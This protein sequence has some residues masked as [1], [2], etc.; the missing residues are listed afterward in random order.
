MREQSADGDFLRGIKDLIP[1]I[2]KEEKWLFFPL[3]G[4]FL[5]FNFYQ[6]SHFSIS[7]DDE[8]AIMSPFPEVWI[9]QGRFIN[10]LF[11]KYLIQRPVMPFVPLAVFGVLVVGGYIFLLKSLRVPTAGSAFLF[12]PI[13]CAFPTW[14]LLTAFQANTPPAGLAVLACGYASWLFRQRCEQDDL[15]LSR[16]APSALI[17]MIAGAVATGCYQSF[18]LFFAITLLLPLL[19]LAREGRSVVRLGQDLRRA[20]LLLI[21]AGAVY[22]GVQRLFFS[23][24]M[25]SEAGAKLNADY[26]LGYVRFEAL[27]T[28]PLTVLRQLLNEA[29]AV[30]LGGNLVY[31]MAAPA[32]ALLTLFV[33]AAS[34]WSGWRRWG[35]RGVIAAAI[36]SA[37]V[38]T[39]PFGLNPMSGGLMPFRSLVGVPVALTGLGLIGFSVLPT[40]GRRVGGLVL[41]ASLLTMLQIEGRYNAT[42]SLVALQDQQLASALA[43]R[44]A[45]LVGPLSLKYPVK[46][47]VFGWR[48]PS[49]P[50]ARADGSTIGA[51]FFE[52]DQ[53]NPYRITAYMRLLGYN[54]VTLSS[55]ER[56][57]DAER[58]K[59]FLRMPAWPAP[60]SVQQESNGTIL[61]KLSE[62]MKLGDGKFDVVNSFYH[63]VLLKDEGEWNIIN[64]NGVF[65]RDGYL[66]IKAQ[67][68]VNFIFKTG[69]ADPLKK[70]KKLEVH[71]QLAVERPDLVQIFYKRPG[72]TEFREEQSLQSAISPGAENGWQQVSFEIESGS[73]FADSFR[74]DPVNQ[75]QRVRLGLVELFCSGQ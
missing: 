1:E 16:S 8:F 72:Q 4:I 6:L 56:L 26:I 59:R 24:L 41:I 52:W 58:L 9:A 18:L 32:F 66:V 34:V 55:E 13:F 68:D 17:I 15:S 54:V 65:S 35:A 19:A 21:A 75:Q 42:R 48:T 20:L 27:L 74:L 53:G 40:W 63:R 38:L 60:D 57:A 37:I 70:C 50:Y 7:I 64:G 62:D 47:D 31:G 49:L 33:V 39:L 12:F 51:S 29:L 28:S 46:V 69:S 61:I 14:S 67:N 44:I 45:V 36:G 23:W 43:R 71:L 2:I 30:Y 25:T 5:F 22:A 3:L 11:E 73:G 10:F